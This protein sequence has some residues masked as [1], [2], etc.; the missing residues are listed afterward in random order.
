MQAYGED[1]DSCC[2]CILSRIRAR[3]KHAE[4]ILRSCTT[5]MLVTYATVS[6]SQFGRSPSIMASIN[7][8]YDDG[9]HNAPLPSAMMR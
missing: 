3:L 8:P 1:S 6:V 5:A 7:T 9:A 2:C 4:K